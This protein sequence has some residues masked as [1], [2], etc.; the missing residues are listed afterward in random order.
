MVVGLIKP[1]GVFLFVLSL[2]HLG[3]G[4]FGN[5]LGAF[6]NSMLCQFTWQHQSH[7][8]LNLTRAESGLLV[9]SG[10][11]SCL[12]SNPFKDV[13]DE[14]VHDGHTLLADTSIR[15]DLL[16]DLVNVGAVSLSALLR[17]FATSS[18]LL[19]GSLGS[20]GRLLRG[21]LHYRREMLADDEGER[22][23][24]DLEHA[25]WPCLR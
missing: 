5:S 1:W 9:V 6:R 10:K 15:V 21:S 14:R 7:S 3:T 18:S 8:S 23:T 25:P 17:L 20:F 16:E 2:L 12:T 4:E 22:E 11:F 24:K 19:G 13:I